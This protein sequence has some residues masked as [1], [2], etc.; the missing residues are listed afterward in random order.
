MWTTYPTLLPTSFFIAS[1]VV[2]GRSPVCSVVRTQGPRSD[3]DRTQRWRGLRAE[4]RIVRCLRVAL[5]F[6]AQAARLRELG[7]DVENAHFYVESARL[8]GATWLLPLVKNY[9]SGCVY[10]LIFVRICC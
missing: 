1:S 7:T 10:L 9:S 6:C 3:A 2:S 5:C 4:V 8:F